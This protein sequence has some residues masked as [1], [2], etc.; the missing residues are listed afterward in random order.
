MRALR[1][2][3]F[4]R[5][6]VAGMGERAGEGMG[7]AF[8]SLVIFLAASIWGLYWVPLRALEGAGFQ[9]GWSVALFNALP[10]AVLVPWVLLAGAGA[11]RGWRIALMVGLFTGLGMA[12]YATGLVLSSVVRATLL[13]Y[14]TPVWST[15]IG[16]LWLGERVDWRRWAAIG[17]G[18]GGL[19]LLLSGGDGASKPLNVGDAF[20]LASGMVWAV[21]IALIKRHPT[22]PVLPMT[23]FQFLFASLGAALA[24]AAITAAPAVE[25]A[26]LASA[27]GFAALCSIGLVMP[28]VLAIFWAGRHVFPGRA[29]L[30]MMSEVLVAVLSAT[31]FLPDERMG[32]VEW[33]GAV[34]IVAACLVE[35]RGLRRSGR[36]GSSAAAGGAAE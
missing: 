10:L 24:A 2:P 3:A 5:G 15:V 16:A 30:L 32:S 14:L 17:L 13:F 35:V 29:G 1:R 6:I 27:L 21:G 19:V 25:T 18:L 31:L 8:P 12:F 11:R 34:L 4:A 28:S 20:G 22:V 7:E 36:R 23:L 9:G 33:M 26:R